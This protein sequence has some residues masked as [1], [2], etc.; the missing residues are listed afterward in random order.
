[1]P[2]NSQSDAVSG[3]QV[4]GDTAV[5]PANAAV[6]RPIGPDVIADYLKRL[7]GSPGVYRMMDREGNVLYVG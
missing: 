4:P 6:Q 5:P 7:P 3:E 1:M 2:T